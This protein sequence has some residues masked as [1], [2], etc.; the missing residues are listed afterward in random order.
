MTPSTVNLRRQS[1]SG[2]GIFALVA[3]LLCFGALNVAVRATWHKVEDGVLWENRPEGVVAVDLS[4]LSSAAAAGIR[5]GDVLIAVDGTP[6]EEQRDVDR[7]LS[8]AD[9]GATLAYTVLRLG[10]HRMLSVPVTS[11][12]RGHT[13]LY[14]ILAGIGFFTL[15]IGASVRLRR[16][17][18][19]AT[20]HFFWLCLA[21]FGTLTF[22]FSRLDRLDW[23]FYWADLVATLMLGPLF[24]HFT[25]VFPERPGSWIR[26]RG[27][28]L[29]PILYLP[30]ALLG[31]ANVLA[32]GRMPLN[33]AAYSRLLTVADQIEPLYLSLYM[34]AG[35]VVLLRARDRVRPRP[36]PAGSCDGSSGG[37]RSASGPSRSATP[38]RMRSRCACRSRW[39]CRSSRS[40]SSRWRSPRRSSGTG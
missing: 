3:V 9:G 35:W 13:T 32:V 28:R 11:A 21:F 20:L 30:A 1:L 34:I 38:C 31:A 23:Y 15:V 27:K 6:I 17:R 37:R 16:P 5:A 2:W 10:E 29:R 19:Q 24:L 4:P 39:S 26:G 14:F 12:P 33:P 8:R 18:D 25:L 22:S 40:A 7:L 36:R